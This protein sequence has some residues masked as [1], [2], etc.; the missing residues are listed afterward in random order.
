M[1][2]YR[3]LALVA[4]VLLAVAG[5]GDEPNTGEGAARSPAI[6]A[7]PPHFW[8]APADTPQ[9]QA[10]V[11]RATRQIDVCALLP[12]DTLVDLDLGEIQDV[13]IGLDSCRAVLGDPAPAEAAT[14]TWHS[15]LLPPLAPRLGIDKHLG[16]VHLL[17]VPDRAPGARACGATA[18]FASG[19]AFYLGLS[20]PNRDSCAIA[21]GLLPGMI[22]RWR[23]S[24]VQGTSPDT[25]DTVLLGADPCAV[26]AKLDGTADTD[27]R[28][29]T[30]CLF[31]YRDE[32]VTVA[33]DYRVTDQ[34]RARAT[35]EKIDDRT[36]FRT[37]SLYDSSIPI[38]SAVVGPE[39]P[40][41]S[42][43]FVP[44]VPAV[45]VTSATDDV[46]RQVMSQVLTLFP[47]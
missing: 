45:E 39:L 38:Y 20:I 34:V 1:T 35:E 26:R 4:A 3:T 10:A 5:C 43:A 23:Q 25:V 16:D 46:A 13:T 12:R 2:V 32:T 17:L 37:T 47:Q 36:V 22:D 42:T 11:A 6:P 28:R 9:Q 30:Q 40:A 29:L 14:L 44:R 19:A 8:S 21:D 33:Y 41:G 7:P 15:T 31:R 18:R 27:E 24:P